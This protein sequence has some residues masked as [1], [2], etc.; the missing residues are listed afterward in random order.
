[1]CSDDIIQSEA[2]EKMNSDADFVAMSKSFV[3]NKVVATHVRT[4]ES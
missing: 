1:M 3:I 4:L 2:T